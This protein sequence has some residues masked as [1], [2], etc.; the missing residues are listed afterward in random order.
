[1][2]NIIT[3]HIPIDDSELEFSAIHASGPGG[4]NVNKLASAVQL[5]FDVLHSP[6]L[7]D[8]VRLRLIKLAGRRINNQGV[9]VIVARQYRTQEQ[10]KQEALRRL[11][12]MLQKASRPP[13]PRHKTKPTLASKQRRLETK[14]RRSQTK[15]MRRKYSGDEG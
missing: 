4:Q 10:N 6:S 14:R 11:E 13:K 12:N 9:L 8:D 3:D 5:R 15:I 2:P 1:M 7:P